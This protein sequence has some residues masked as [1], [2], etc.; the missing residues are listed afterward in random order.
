MARFFIWPRG[1]SFPASASIWAWTGRA[2]SLSALTAFLGCMAAAA[3]WNEITERTGFFY[4]CLTW[5]IAGVLGVF[6]S[7]DLFLFYFAWEFMLVPMYF[8]IN[9]VGP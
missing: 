4:L 9:P 7:L 1:S 3:S 6:L 2:W 8:L 5:T